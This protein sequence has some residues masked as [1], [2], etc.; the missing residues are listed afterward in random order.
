VYRDANVVNANSYNTASLMTDGWNVPEGLI[1]IMHPGVDTQT[2]RPAPRDPNWRRRFGW[3]DRRVVLTVGRLTKRKGHE[4]LIQALP[5]IAQSVPNVLYAII[6]DGEERQSLET[7]VSDLDICDRVAFHGELANDDVGRA[8]QQCDLFALPNWRYQGG[9][10]G[11]G[12]VL[13]EAQACGK[14][15]IA[16]DSGGTTEAINA[17]HSGRIVRPDRIEELARAVGELLSDDAL[18]ERMGQIGRQWVVQHFDWDVLIK[19]ANEIFSC[20]SMRCATAQAPEAAS[21]IID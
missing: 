4:F 2:F 20:L 18:R 19:D 3:G 21:S 5:R 17:P 7:L 12:I 15:A 10:E 14:P 13:L 11:F 1:R 8:H 9:T 6:G 16:G